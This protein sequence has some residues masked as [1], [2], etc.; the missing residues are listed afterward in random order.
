MQKIMQIM[1]RT[2]HQ[3]LLLGMA[4]A[5][6]G[7]HAVDSQD[8]QDARVPRTYVDKIVPYEYN[9]RR[10]E[11][12]QA[13]QPNMKFNGTFY[14]VPY[15][16]PPRSGIYEPYRDADLAWID[17]LPLED[18]IRINLRQNPST[19]PYADQIMVTNYEG[20]VVLEGVVRFV[21]DRSQIQAVVQQTNGVYRVDN[22]I[23]MAPIGRRAAPSQI[24][25]RSDSR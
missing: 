22:R 15:Q 3:V 12:Q 9:E 23:T 6:V 7:L 17:S 2:A 14:E 16:K 21:S 24:L 4:S 20:M 1:H 25:P 5:W 13:Q 11:Q 10:Q 18:R 8:S 19:A